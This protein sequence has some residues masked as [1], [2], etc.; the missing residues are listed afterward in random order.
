MTVLPGKRVLLAL[1]LFVLALAI[2]PLSGDKYWIKLVTRMIALGIFAM[3]LDFIVGYTGLVSF[4]HAAFF[5][6]AGYVLHLISPEDAAANLLWALPVSIG[7]AGLLAAVIGAMSVRTR[8]IYFIMVTLA[9]AQMVFFFFHDSDIAGGSDGAFIF[10]KPAL[11]LGDIVLFD[12]GKRTT[13]F[14]FS[15]GSMVALYALLVVVLRSP[16]G[17]VIQGIKVNEHRMRALGYN[18]YL[19]KWVAFIIA[20][21]LGGYAGFLFACIDGFVPPELLSWRESGIALVM[22]ILGGIGTLFGPVLGAFTLLGV[23]EILRDRHIFG[24]FSM[25]WQIMLGGFIIVVVLFLSNG[26]GGLLM[27]LGAGRKGGEE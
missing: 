12:L 19:Y 11:A 20:G 10:F 17:Q 23:E 6:T 18:T 13:L 25:H 1:A 21:V 4:G 8:G 7:A 2:V 16:F 24:A 9:F 5:G 22:V 14:V 27:R 3:S 26:I 15:L